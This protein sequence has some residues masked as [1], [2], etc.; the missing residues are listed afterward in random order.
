MESKEILTVLLSQKIL[1]ETKKLQ[2]WKSKLERST[3]AILDKFLYIVYLYQRGLSTQIL[4]TYFFILW[5]KMS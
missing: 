5:I 3:K 4:I 2:L 1:K